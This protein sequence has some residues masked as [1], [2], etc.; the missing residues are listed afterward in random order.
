VWAAGH[1]PYLGHLPGDFYIKRG[2]WSFYFP[3]TTCIVLSIVLTFLLS[4]LRR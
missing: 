4:L 2:D 3:V 1:V